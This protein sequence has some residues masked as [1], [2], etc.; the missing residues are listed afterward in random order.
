[1][2]E[3]ITQK[4][5]KAEIDKFD[6][7]QSIKYKDEKLTGGVIYSMISEKRNFLNGTLIIS[8]L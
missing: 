1:M 7:L 5:T 4:P 3:L 6:I 2:S 8:D